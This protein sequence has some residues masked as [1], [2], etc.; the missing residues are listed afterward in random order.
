MSRLFAQPKHASV[1]VLVFL[2]IARC[3]AAI[4]VSNLGEPTH[5]AATA[6]ANFQ[7]AESFVAG[8]DATLGAVNLS[9]ALNPVSAGLVVTLRTDAGGSP[10][11]SALATLSGSPG[12]SRFEALSAPALSA[13][14]TYWVVAAASAPLVE[15]NATSGT[16]QTGLSGWLIGNDHKERGFGGPWV[17]VSDSLKLSLEATPVPEPGSMAVAG[18]GVF[19]WALLRHRSRGR[20]S[21]R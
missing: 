4:L 6:D 20:T 17:L 19:G 21:R 3:D 1:A 15:W 2:S 13:G 9:L 10:A 7:L 14:T 18:L 16:A 11:A 12:G 8:S 5:L